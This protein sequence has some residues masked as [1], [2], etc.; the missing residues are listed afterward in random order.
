M[1]KVCKTCKQ[2]KNVSFYYKHA[3]NKDGLDKSCK[4]CRQDYYNNKYNKKGR[5]KHL[6][7]EVGSYN[8]TRNS[9]LVCTYGI[10]LK[11][12]NILLES[13]NYKCAICGIVQEESLRL[14]KR[15]LFVDHCHNTSRVRGL[16]CQ[17]CNNGLGNFK[18]STEFL[19]KAINYLK[20]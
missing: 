3:S 10:T 19:D 18:D 8:Y 2:D 17:N 5:S 9:H 16:L 1:G 12:Y 14:F 15:L 13:Q 11:E 20:K 7:Y 6:E 4:R